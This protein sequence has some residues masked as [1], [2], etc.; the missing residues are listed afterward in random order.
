MKR[1]VS[2]KVVK[3]TKYKI[4]L[5]KL[6]IGV[7]ILL[8]I[9]IGVNVYLKKTNKDK[10]L[11][12][13]GANAFGNIL[14]SY[15]YFYNKDYLEQNSYGFAI[16]DNKEVS[17]SK[18][19]ITDLVIEKNPVV[20]IYNTF[21]TDK[22]TNNYYNSYN[23]NP[24]ITQASL[25]LQEYL[26]KEGINSVVELNSVAKVLK[27]NNIDYSL[28]YRGS[29][30]LLEQAKRENKTLKYFIDLQLSDSDYTMTTYKKGTQAYAKVLWVLG[31]DNE[32]YAKNEEVIK[33]LDTKLKE[34]D[35]SISRGISYRGGAGY[36]GV[37]NQD[38]DENVMLIQVGGR[39]NTIAEVNETLKV[40]AK[41]IAWKVRGE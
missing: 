34:Y 10:V 41:V 18:N 39:K 2:K 30:I 7:L 19:N 21:Q 24:V 11:N 32:N 17:N 28:S 27:D 20:Y 33:S 25:I 16:K 5:A 13:V 23:I 1:F 31:T 8:G 4:L 9:N 38:W 29:K 15:R 37:Y 35:E 6:I 40:L 3:V 26:K 14:D 36:Q 22:Y 12:Y